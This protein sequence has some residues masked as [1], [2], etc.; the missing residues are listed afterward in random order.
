MAVN[1]R[2]GLGSKQEDV[3]SQY[4]RRVDYP[5]PSGMKHGVPS[6]ASL[7]SATSPRSHRSRGEVV[8]DQMAERGAKQ[9][10]IARCVLGEEQAWRDLHRQY[11]PVVSRFLRRM[12]IHAGDLEDACQEVFVQVFRYLGRF[13]QRADFGTWLYKLCLSQAGRMGRRRRVREA[14]GWLFGRDPSR[15]TETVELEW[16]ASMVTER[17]GKALQQMKPQHKAVFVLFEFEGVEGKEIARILRCP[18]ATVRRRLHY[19]RQEF[20]TLVR[21]E[22]AEDGNS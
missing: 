16:S 7:G 6:P 3:T 10:L 17:V 8:S 22:A 1:I 12:G 14:L 5:D 19:A 4:R 11:Y 18:P 9:P 21:A 2:S 15:P 20:E 13:E